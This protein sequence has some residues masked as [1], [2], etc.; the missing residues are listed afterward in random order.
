MKNGRK[1]KKTNFG[2]ILCNNLYFDSRGS[3]YTQSDV[4][5]KHKN[6]IIRNYTNFFE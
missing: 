1:K 4:V 6:K 3:D 2:I 5:I